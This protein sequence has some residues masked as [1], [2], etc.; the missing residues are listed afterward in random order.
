MDLLDLLMHPTKANQRY[1]PLTAPLTEGQAKELRWVFNRVREGEHRARVRGERTYAS[2]DPV[3]CQAYARDASSFPDNLEMLIK[4][5]PG[6]VVMPKD[7]GELAELTRFAENGNVPLTPRGAGTGFFGGAVPAEG[8]VVVDMRGFDEVVEID[9]E[10]GRVVTQAG[11]SWTDLEARLNEEGLSLKAT[12]FASPLSTIGGWVATGGGGFGSLKSGTVRDMLVEAKVV[13]PDGE[14]ATYTGGDLDLVEGCCGTTGFIVEVTL[15][16][17]EHVETVPRA[18]SFETVDEVQAYLKRTAGLPIRSLHV[19]GPE[20][21]DLKQEALSSRTLPKGNFLVLTALADDD[22]VDQTT[23]RLE[24]VCEA[25]GGEV[26]SE[27]AAA[28]EWDHRFHHHCFKR[29]GPSL[30]TGHAVVDKDRL[31]EAWT[32]GAEAIKAPEWAIW[33]VAISPDEVLLQ[34]AIVADERLPNYPLAVGNAVAFEDAAQGS[35]GRPYTAGLLHAGQAK[36]ILGKARVK[37]LSA[38]KKEHDKQEVM[39]PGKVI[40]ARVKGLPIVRL[41]TALGPGMGTFKAMRGGFD[42]RRGSGPDTSNRALHASAGRRLSPRL[43]DLADDLYK[44]SG[45]GHTNLTGDLH[46]GIIHEDEKPRRIVRAYRFDTQLPRG[47]VSAAKAILEGHVPE[48]DTAGHA[49]STPCVPTYEAQSQN[50]VPILEA[51]EGVREAAQRAAGLDTRVATLIDSLEAGGNLLA[52]DPEARGDWLPGGTPAGTDTTSLLIAGDIACYEQTDAAAAA[53]RVLN[54]AG[55]GFT[56][57]GPKETHPGT[58][59]YRLGA[60]DAAAQA[61]QS[62]A[63]TAQ[64]HLDGTLPASLVTL[65]NEDADV[66]GRRLGDLVAGSDV[67]GWDPRVRS[68]AQVVA[69]LVS[70]GRLT[71]KGGAS[72]EAPEEA[73]ADADAEEDG[74]VQEDEDPDDQASEDAD[75]GAEEATDEESDE[76]EDAEPEEISLTIVHSPF[77]DSDE[78][79]ALEGV[80]D[81]MPGV[82]AT[83]ADLDTIV[84]DVGLHLTHAADAKELTTRIK[85]ALDTQALVACTDLAHV[86]SQS[87]VDMITLP[88]LVEQRMEVREGAGATMEVAAEEEEE[89]FKE[90]EIPE[91]AYRVEL[92]KEEAAIP[93]YPD[94]SILDAAEEFGFDLPFDCRAGSCVTCSARWEGTEPD[95]SEV[96]AIDEEEQKTHCLTCVTKPKGDIKIWSDEAP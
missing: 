59:A 58:I 70:S 3:V 90:H 62:F 63:E 9:T 80:V 49:L 67:A 45:L 46:R 12:P 1:S 23:E 72:D 91:G 79:S 40:P 50:G 86:L 96:Q 38:W 32:A 35:G 30:A 95:Q 31:A 28:W 26:V 57:L 5:T 65:S 44:C 22:Q 24:T 41:N 77:A 11:I 64:S 6:A 84:P 55:F 87:R 2:D 93:V 94:Q 37:R 66:L 42:H 39:N 51:I 4:G 27:D 10:A 76:G 71:F 7:R 8:G 20:H 52:E 89:G 81:A 33:A 29:F 60:F 19:L 47:I 43:A 36:E 14:L 78:R 21:V 48:A 69:E 25:V 88:E 75:G 16:V 82:T 68:F 13:T 53:F 74:E 73:S 83:V 54:N 85:D 56:T 34:A 17:Q 18:A 61:C 92:V 15:D